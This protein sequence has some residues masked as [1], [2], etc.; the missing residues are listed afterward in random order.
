MSASP[1]D[2][3]TYVGDPGTATNLASP[4]YTSGGASINTT[5][6]THFPTL[7]GVIFAIDEVQTVN[8]EEVRVA[9][10][11][12]EY[13]GIVASGTAINNVDWLN[14]DGDRDY[15][16]GS[17]TRVYVTT[18]A[19]WA[20]RLVEGLLVSHNP[21][22]TMKTSLPLTTP[23]IGSAGANFSGSSSGTTALKAAATASGT[24]TLP[25]ATDTLVGKATTDTLTNKTIAG[26]TNSVSANTFTNPYK[27]LVYLAAASQTI[28]TS[29]DTVVLCDAK[30][31][32]TG[33]NVDVVTNKGRFTAPV[34]GFY[35][36]SA[37]ASGV[38]NSGAAWIVGLKKNGT[39]I[40]RLSQ[41]PFWVGGTITLQLAAT[42]YV[43]VFVFQ[44]VGSSQ[45]LSGAGGTF[46]SSALLTFFSG[47]LVSTT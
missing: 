18:A 33:T 36:F 16:A 24:V 1:T 34:A 12:N 47:Y 3:I 35:S 15:S 23:A 29:T 21:D 40:V 39:S 27:F 14:G 7:T 42:D 17:S 43:E 38:F 20:N 8:G 44:S 19:A 11:Y 22:G 32:D 41:G 31:Y 30:V 25:A 2:K 46:P 6:T 10:T 37:V 26:S 45:T 28:T 13:F 9:G 4:G 5:T